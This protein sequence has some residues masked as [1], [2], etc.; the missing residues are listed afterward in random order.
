MTNV[1]ALQTLD[2]LDAIVTGCSSQVSCQSNASCTSHRS[3]A[4]Y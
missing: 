4:K 3:K 2:T 1:L